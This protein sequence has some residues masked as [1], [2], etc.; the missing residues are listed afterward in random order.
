MSPEFIAVAVS[1]L[2]DLAVILAFVIQRQNQKTREDMERGRN[3]QI[4]KDIQADLDRAHVKIR[5]LDERIR[6][7]DGDL[8]EIKTD[9]KHLLDAVDR[10]AVKLDR[11][12]E[13]GAGQ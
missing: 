2:A 6:G 1:F 13:A 5:D 12:L 4:I 7:S 10:V 3:E 11:H 9:V 8:R